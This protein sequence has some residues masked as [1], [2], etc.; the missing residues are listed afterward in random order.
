[1]VKPQRV[2]NTKNW[3]TESTTDHTLYGKGRN[4]STPYAARG[5]TNQHHTLHGK[6]PTGSIRGHTLCC[7]RPTLHSFF[8]TVL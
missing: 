8:G 2:V 5:V 3:P 1:M 4:E 7:N 6:G